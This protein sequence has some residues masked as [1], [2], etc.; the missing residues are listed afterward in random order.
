MATWRHGQMLSVVIAWELSQ[1]FRCQQHQGIVLL[2]CMVLWYN[3]EDF[4]AVQSPHQ[5]LF[6]TASLALQSE[7]L[8]S[9]DKWG[10]CFK[11][12]KST[13]VYMLVLCLCTRPVGW[14][15]LLPV[16]TCFSRWMLL[17]LLELTLTFSKR[18]GWKEAEH[19]IGLVKDKYLCLYNVIIGVGT[20]F[21]VSVYCFKFKLAVFDY[22]TILRCEFQI[23]ILMQLFSSALL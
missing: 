9:K 3:L 8:V 4:T 12:H 19:L 1:C 5:Q 11:C 23:F 6:C 20:L 22:C 18:Q 21:W 15:V 2:W 14:S 13:P 7:C 16:L 17:R 10:I